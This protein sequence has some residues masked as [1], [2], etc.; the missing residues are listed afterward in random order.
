MKVAIMQPY[1]FPYIGYFSLIKQTDLFILLDEVQFMRHGWIER[2]RI[3]KQ[4]DGWLYIKV[5]LVKESSYCKISSIKI[6]NTQDWKNKIRSQLQP[7]KK[8]AKYYTEVKNIVEEIFENEYDSIT[9]L[10]LLSTKRICDYLNISTPIDS[11]SDSNIEIQAPKAPDEWALNI[12]TSLKNVSE[13]WNP[14]GG[15]EFFDV[16]KY[17]DANIQVKFL[18]H[19]L[20]EYSQNRGTFL[21]GLSIIDVLMF[22]SVEDA[23]IMIDQFT[24]ETD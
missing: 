19:H 9:Q 18:K 10:N 4:N 8:V 22:N 23:N 15:K 1:F 11:F 21:P 14:I 20:P 6:D 12:C 2:N 24:I 17:K 5:P 16:K 7:Y 3:L 13:Y